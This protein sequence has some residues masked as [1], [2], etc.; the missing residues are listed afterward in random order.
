[1]KNNLLKKLIIT[2]F[3]IILFLFF[4]NN[5]S[6]A[7][8]SAQY[9]ANENISVTINDNGILTVSGKGEMPDYNNKTAPWYSDVVENSKYKVTKI[10]I[11]NGITK[12]GKLSFQGFSSVTDITFPNSLTEIGEG[13]FIECS[14]LTSFI[15]PSSLKTIKEGAFAKCTELKTIKLNEGLETLDMYVFQEI[16]A[17][18]ITI[19]STLKEARGET[20]WNAKNLKEF[21]VTSG[22]KEFFVDKGVLYKDPSAYTN[23]YLIA[24]PIANTMTEYTIKDGT[25]NI[26]QFAFMNAKN[27]KKVNI[28]ESIYGIGAYSFWKSGLT[29]LTVPKLDL[30]FFGPCAWQ[31]CTALE[32]VEFNAKVPTQLPSG[33]FGNCTNLKNVK[34]SGE[35]DMIHTFY[36]DCFENCTSLKKIALPEGTKEIYYHAFEGCTSLE[37]VVWPSSI[38]SVSQSGFE[39][40]D[41]LKQKYPIGFELQSDHYYRAKPINIKITGEFNYEYAQEVL[42]IVN[43]ERAKVGA[44]AL[45]MSKELFDTANKR[46]AEIAVCYSH[47]RPDGSDCFTIFPQSTSE[48]VG[49]K[50][51]SG[52]NIA[53]GYGS[54]ESV[55]N[56]WMNSSGHKANI[57]SS[58]FTAIGIGC[59]YH[60]GSYYWVQCFLDSGNSMSSYP[61]NETK[62]M[63][64]SVT[65]GAID[66]SLNEKFTASID[67]DEK[68]VIYGTHSESD[69][70][71]KFIYDLDNFT[72]DVKDTSVLSITD[73]NIRGKKLASTDIT[74]KLKNINKSITANVTVID[75]DATIEWDNLDQIIRLYKGNTFQLK[76]KINSKYLKEDDVEWSTNDESA[77]KVDNK[78]QLTF[79]KTGSAYVYA[80]LPNGNYISKRVV[81]SNGYP[82]TNVTISKNTLTLEKGKSETLTGRYEPFYTTDDTKMNWSS[83]NTKVAT[84]DS[85]GK[86]TAIGVGTATITLKIGNMSSKCTVTV[87]EAPKYK[88]GDINNDG[89][90][91]L[92]DV[93][94][95]LKGISRGTLTEVENMAGDVNKDKKCNL[96]DMIIILQFTAGKITSFE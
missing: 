46:A 13:A 90:V 96:R 70:S 68:L 3:L 24:F 91:N 4:N 38:I 63:I 41:K 12:I 94:Y 95:G 27:L 72:C 42:K 53:A 65:P 59:F 88:L 48:S 40:C 7:A 44:K 79:V 39:G 26:D 87:K 60:N 30:I 6:L 57:L 22:A 36:A 51:G 83:S 61:A 15:A 1:M 50:I 62:Q 11:E 19:P 73:G 67:K 77:L 32:T 76:V 78:G 89:R 21:K 52:E 43:E 66:I 9:K 86:V 18:E 31:D 54:P 23:V 58:N 34:F 56:G 37:E 33:T 5:F 71:R 16:A 17:T 92:S 45:V 74:I 28:P 49:I 64:I 85:N 14:K 93:I 75:K 8:N 69:W 80:K 2:L 82:I 55:M 81:S 84:V 10:V 20:F 35:N 47:T 29:S 25:T